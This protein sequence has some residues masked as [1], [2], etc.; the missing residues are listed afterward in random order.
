MFKIKYSCK[1]YVS[2]VKENLKEEISG[3][4][5]KP[6]LVVIQIDDN[7]ASN[8]YIKGKKKDCEEVGIRCIHVKLNSNEHSQK[9]LENIINE[10]DNSMNVHGIIIQ[11]PIPDKYDIDRLQHCVSPE[12]DVDGFRVDSK[13]KPCTPK[14]I[15]DWL[16][17]NNYDFVGK[18]AVVIGRSKI[19]GKPLV[20]ML[21]DKG[22][23]VS[24]CNS[25][26]TLFARIRLLQNANLVVSAIGKPHFFDCHD[27]YKPIIG[28]NLEVVVDV[29]I[30]HDENGKLCGDVNG[31]DFEKFLPDTY[32]TP[33][34]GSVGLLTRVT[35]LTNLMRSY[36]T[37][38]VN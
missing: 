9:D 13:H 14:G 6:T 24:C 20:N 22:A 38:E 29:G 37:L 5:V 12:K 17:Y 11:L 15:L 32:L 30:N 27:F 1:E 33:V 23:T 35:L 16:E 10:Y 36:Y 18:N 3:L 28:N 26:T 31:K 2:H 8:S 4:K 7:P 25:H 21:I 34:P 19:V